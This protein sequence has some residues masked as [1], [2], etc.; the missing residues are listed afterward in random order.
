LRSGDLRWPVRLR[1]AP[2]RLALHIVILIFPDTA[3]V[4][5]ILA[6]VAWRRAVGRL[7]RHALLADTVSVFHEWSPRN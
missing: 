2:G 7:V 1:V 3:L 6:L 4:G 5:G